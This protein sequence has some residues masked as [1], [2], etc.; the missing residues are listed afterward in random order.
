MYAHSLKCILLAVCGVLVS[1]CVYQGGERGKHEIQ[2]P[3]G[4]TVT[5]IEPP[6]EVVKKASV[7]TDI[8]ASAKEIGALAKASVRGE[9]SPERI[10]EKLPSNV[11]AF[12]VIEFR[13]CMGYANG[14][15]SPQEYRAFLDAR[16]GLPS[17]S[18]SKESRKS[19]LKE[20]VAVDTVRQQL[21]QYMEE[22]MALVKDLDVD[23]KKVVP[24][25]KQKVNVWATKITSYVEN[26]FVDPTY[27]LRLRN[28]SDLHPPGI[29]SVAPFS[30]EWL[31]YR[32]AVMLRLTRL[33]QFLDSIH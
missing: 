11:A 7:A 29:P 12:E 16:S 2:K 31:G 28:F 6:P 5:C 21:I 27:V 24:E 25:N 8:D 32:A 3:D 9:V 13:L 26:N 10:R 30:D 20:G 22:G 23:P 4:T 17:L 18:P 15:Y 19:P 33:N 1:S 14:L